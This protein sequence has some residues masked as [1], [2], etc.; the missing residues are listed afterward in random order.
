VA[1]EWFALHG[2]LRACRRRVPYYAPAPPSIEAE[3]RGRD[4]RPASVGSLGGG[5]PGV[6]TAC[7]AVWAASVTGAAVATVAGAAFRRRLRT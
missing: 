5:V 1:A 6:A 7:V 2:R 3:R 4:V